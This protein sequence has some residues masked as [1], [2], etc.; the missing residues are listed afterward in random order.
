[1]RCEQERFRIATQPQTRL[2]QDAHAASNRLTTIERDDQ[3]E[4]L[5]R[6]ERAEL[7]AAARGKAPPDDTLPP[8]ATSLAVL[9]NPVTT[10]NATAILDA[11]A[12]LSRAPSPHCA[13]RRA[14]ESVRI[15]FL[16]G[17]TA[18]SYATRHACD[19]TSTKSNSLKGGSE[20]C[21]T[22]AEPTTVEHEGEAVWSLRSEF[23]ELPYCSSAQQYADKICSLTHH[24]WATNGLLPEATRL[25]G[26]YALN[27]TPDGAY[28]RSIVDCAD[29]FWKQ[30]HFHESC[31]CRFSNFVMNDETYAGLEFSMKFVKCVPRPQNGDSEVPLTHPSVYHGLLL[32]QQGKEAECKEFCESI[33]Q[34]ESD[35]ARAE[36]RELGVFGLRPPM[37]SAEEV[38][39]PHLLFMTAHSTTFGKSVSS[40]GLLASPGRR[41]YSSVHGIAQLRYR[42]LPVD[43]EI[44]SQAYVLPCQKSSCNPKK[45]LRFEPMWAALDEAVKEYAHVFGYEQPQD[46]DVRKRRTREEI[47]FQELTKVAPPTTEQNQTNILL[48][49]PLACNAF[50]VGDIYNVLRGQKA[51][52]SVCGFLL[53]TASKF[54]S[55]TSIET[56]FESASKTLLEIDKKTAQYENEINALKRKLAESELQVEVL[57]KKNFKK[58]A[59]VEEKK[60]VKQ[61]LNTQ[62]ATAKPVRASMTCDASEM[63]KLLKSAFNLKMGPAKNLKCD[64]G[65]CDVRTVCRAIEDTFNAASLTLEKT[66]QIWALDHFKKLPTIPTVRQALSE[67]FSHSVKNLLKVYDFDKKNEWQVPVLIWFAKDCTVRTYMI[68][69]NGTSR[70]A[71]PLSVLDVEADRTP[72]AFFYEKKCQLGFFTA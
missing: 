63:K 7:E 34:E 68:D 9:V 41:L 33:R 58:A 45:W 23:A 46:S 50:T 38:V 43:G 29:Q 2:V 12:H 54:G 24:L 60:D 20:L 67:L 19:A 61:L 51:A 64:F 25:L 55:E 5:L 10:A 72:I 30:L 6:A 26:S 47:D 53:A 52:P 36:G 13:H 3:L 16:A 17:T 48:G 22:W 4:R 44:L 14:V 28:V 31:N 39:C 42:L 57:K 8:R 21:L 37:T 59:P 35:R 18:R 69:E 1:M 11:V 65:S 27:E 71:S 70:I 56:V 32:H 40:Y 62:E 49:V 66:T 15:V